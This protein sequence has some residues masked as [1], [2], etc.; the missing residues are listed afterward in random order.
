[1]DQALA[2]V[3]DGDTFTF[4]KLDRLARSVP[5]A[6]AILSQLSDRSVRIA[7]AVRSTTDTIRWRHER[8]HRPAWSAVCRLLPDSVLP[9]GMPALAL[10]HFCDL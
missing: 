1:V 8:C 4:T 9:G 7:L 5:D 6:L 2:A 3:R 10:K